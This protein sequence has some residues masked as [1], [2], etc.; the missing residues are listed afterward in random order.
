MRCAYV[1]DILHDWKDLDVWRWNEFPVTLQHISMPV[2][3][4]KILDMLA[5]L[6]NLTSLEIVGPLP[7]F[8]RQKECLSEMLVPF[9][10]S[11]TRLELA[12]CAIRDPCLVPKNL[13]FLKVK[14][15]KWN[16]N[17]ILQLPNTLQTLFV[18]HGIKNIYIPEN[19]H[20]LAIVGSGCTFANPKNII[21]LGFE[22]V[23]RS[24]FVYFQNLLS[25]NLELDIKQ[26]INNLTFPPLMLKLQLSFSHVKTIEVLNGKI[27]PNSLKILGLKNL[28]VKELLL[29]D[30]KLLEFVGFFVASSQCSRL[31]IPCGLKLI[32]SDAIDIECL[33]I[34]LNLIHHRVCIILTL[35]NFRNYKNESIEEYEETIFSHKFSFP[36]PFSFSVLACFEIQIE[37]ILRKYYAFNPYDNSEESMFS[38]WLKLF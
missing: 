24:S 31:T 22:D 36:F 9:H 37:N 35:V 28:F 8:Y 23:I 20:T 6:P 12:D 17:H 33:M 19:V 5:V 38:H 16:A 21:N 4:K 25:L 18:T 10:M 3:P 1:G 14:K 13:Q 34:L 27:F 30:C 32:V 2:P 11:L 15:L 26:D 7:R 29:E